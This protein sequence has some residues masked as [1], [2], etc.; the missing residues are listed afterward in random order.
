MIHGGT[1]AAVSIDE[2]LELARKFSSEDSVQFLNGVL[3]AVHRA[4]PT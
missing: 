3:D 1:P 2:A 4:L